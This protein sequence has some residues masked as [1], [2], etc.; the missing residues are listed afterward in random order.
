MRGPRPGPTIYVMPGTRSA[1]SIRRAGRYLSVGAAIV[2]VGLMATVIF[3]A[4][5]NR[6]LSEDASAAGDDAARYGPVTGLIAEQHALLPDYL[7][8][9][10]AAIRAKFEAIDAETDAL[11]AS[12]VEDDGAEAELL[13]RAE[14]AHHSAIRRFFAAVDAGHPPRARTS[15]G[16]QG[17]P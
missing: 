10:P 6:L 17:G 7:D 8:E 15:R 2:F 1:A 12:L 16:V 11:I 3:T 14:G 9:D 5:S 13:D 4:V